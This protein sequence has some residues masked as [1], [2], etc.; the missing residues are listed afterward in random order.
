VLH[1]G[2]EGLASGRGPLHTNEILEFLT[3]G[4]ELG[5]TSVKFTGGEPFLRP[6]QELTHLFTQLHDYGQFECIELVTNGTLMFPALDLLQETLSV[7]TISI[8]TL[9]PKKYKLFTGG[10]CLRNV[11]NNME[12]FR[13]SG[14]HLRI[15]YVLAQSN[16]NEV[17]AILKYAQSLG[18]ELKLLD[19]L[20]FRIPKNMS[21]EYCPTSNVIEKL[22]LLEEQGAILTPP[23][24]FGV[25]MLKFTTPG[26]PVIIK[27]SAFGTVYNDLCRNCIA[28]PCQDGL[29][30][31]RI[32]H[33]GII[34]MCWPREDLIVTYDGLHNISQQLRTALEWYSSP[35][36]RKAWRLKKT[37]NQYGTNIHKLKTSGL[38]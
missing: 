30:G 37:G 14:I 27:D 17:P 32:T 9:K 38:L 25:P 3:K 22:S 2:G 16:Y 19:L 8:D 28:F 4:A 33:D 21:H 26:G 15:N 5:F 12:H 18:A 10:G 13:R 1:K 24:G 35:Y 11:L 20:L 34:R 29:Y 6:A 36:F 7:L 31:L 23:G